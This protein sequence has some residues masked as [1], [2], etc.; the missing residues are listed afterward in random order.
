MLE[1]LPDKVS[2]AAAP[3]AHTLLASAGAF[4]PRALPAALPWAAGF[5]DGAQLLLSSPD[6]V[7]SRPFSWSVVSDLPP[8]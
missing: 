8:P 3:T 4:L 6:V 2:G 7:L 1:S 5:L